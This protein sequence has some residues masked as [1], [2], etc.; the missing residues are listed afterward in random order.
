MVPPDTPWESDAAA[1][2]ELVAQNLHAGCVYTDG[3]S[4]AD[5][6]TP[7]SGGEEEKVLPECLSRMALSYSACQTLN[8][9]SKRIQQRGKRAPALF[10]TLNGTRD[11]FC[12]GFQSDAPRTT[13]FPRENPP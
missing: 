3:A 10:L 8:L 1:L 2:D 11:S 12:A 6:Y 13:R 7:C 4:A 5:T 9:L